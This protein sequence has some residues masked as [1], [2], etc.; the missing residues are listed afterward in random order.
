MPTISVPRQ[1]FN[2]VIL[3]QITIF[4]DE[5]LARLNIEYLKNRPNHKM[6]GGEK[7]LAA[8]ATVLAMEPEA[9]LMDE[10]SSVLAPKNRRNLINILNDLSRESNITMVIATHDLDLVLDT[11]DRVVIL[12]S[13]AMTADGPATD[14]LKG[15]ELLEANALELPLSISGSRNLHCPEEV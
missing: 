3:P 8:I 1:L 14:I 7:R 5:V 15:R 11:C 2:I 13:G 4:R 12:N 6:S 10:T 9:L